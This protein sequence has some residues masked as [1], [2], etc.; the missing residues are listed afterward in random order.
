MTLAQLQSRL[1]KYI[2]NVRVRQGG[3]A[4]VASIYAGNQYLVRLNKGELHLYN[5]RGFVKVTD[6]DRMLALKGRALPRGGKHRGRMQAL[7]MLVN[8]RWL[9]ARQAQRVMWGL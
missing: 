1:E 2:P 9:N 6:E 8:M 3:Y 5:W 7:N 4:D